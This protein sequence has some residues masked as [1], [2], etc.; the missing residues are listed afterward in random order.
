MLLVCAGTA[1]CIDPALI[2]DR[3]E[4]REPVYTPLAELDLPGH[5][6]ADVELAE[7]LGIRHGDSFRGREDVGDLRR[8]RDACTDAL[9]TEIA[10]RHRV[11][12]AELVGARGRRS[13]GADFLTVF[14]PMALVFVLAAGWGAGRIFHRFPPSLEPRPA[15]ILTVVMSLVVAALG[16][17]IGDMWSWQV[18]AWR[19]GND[20][21]S[22]RAFYRPWVRHSGG[23]FAATVVLCWVVAAGR[24]RAYGSSR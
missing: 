4:W 13:V 18:E 9:L 2:N 11:T 6:A 16:Y 15:L 7:E 20:H 17:A 12:T 3:C 10:R 19:L 22:Y 24:A 5:L 21:L 8:K 23:V 1:G 14:A